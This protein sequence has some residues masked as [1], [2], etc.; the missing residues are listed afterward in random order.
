MTSA[1]VE[2][3]RMLGLLDH[4]SGPEELDEIA[5]QINK[6]V[7]E[8]DDAMLWLVEYRKDLE[9]RF[10][11]A[12]VQKAHVQAR[13]GLLSLAIAGGTVL[14]GEDGRMRASGSIAP[15]QS[16]AQAGT[17][18][19]PA[20]DRNLT[21]MMLLETCASI[22]PLEQIDLEQAIERL[23]IE[24]PLIGGPGGG[25]DPFEISKLVSFY[26]LLDMLATGSY[27]LLH[28]SDAASAIASDPPAMAA[29][30]P[31][32]F[33]RVWIEMC[34]AYNEPVPMVTYEVADGPPADKRDIHV[35]GV[36]L[37][38]VT[39]SREWD[40]MIPLQ[41][42]EQPE[43]SVLGMRIGPNGI[44]HLLGAPDGQVG[45]VEQAAWV[46]IRQIAIGGAHLISARNVP[47]ERVTLP[48]AQ[49]KRI[50]RTEIA[51]GLPAQD[52]IYFV[53][54]HASG[55]HE[56]DGEPSGRVYTVRWL[57][58]GHWRHIDSGRSLCTCCT[59]ARTARWI[60]PYVKG[61]VGAPWKGRQVRVPGHPPKEET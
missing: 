53:N 46:V 30:P 41:F 7:S 56:G 19:G 24:M 22:V 26:G 47:H 3:K 35:L 5:L 38:E 11:S 4:A 12:R 14:L 57:V 31:L 25:P 52:R 15:L 32:P 6:H 55:E 42:G 34:G 60:H 9:A 13:M 20:G 40:V 48:R 2:L 45:D 23:R 43:W 39:P 59:P 61:P 36:A 18:V 37:H 27:Y 54:L 51:R 28:A 21:A 8:N 33:P 58:S 17:R 10:D 49:R 44:L 50:Q 1:I 16:V 29:L